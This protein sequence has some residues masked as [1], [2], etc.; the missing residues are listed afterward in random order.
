MVLASRRPQYTLDLPIPSVLSQGLCIKNLYMFVC[1][2]AR[3]LIPVY[4]Y[5]V[6]YCE[7]RRVGLGVHAHDQQDGICV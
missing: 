6:A 2:C 4:M 5:T 7:L 3:L 1:V